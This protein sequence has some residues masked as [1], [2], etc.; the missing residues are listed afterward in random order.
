MNGCWGYLV[1]GNSLLRDDVRD[2]SRDLHSATRSQGLDYT[3]T[4]KNGCRK[5]NMGK[6][7]ENEASKLLCGCNYQGGR[8]DRP[9]SLRLMNQRQPIIIDFSPLFLLF[10]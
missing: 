8:R 6:D 5:K 2:P 1:M 7:D 10:F 3:T 9:A 4:E